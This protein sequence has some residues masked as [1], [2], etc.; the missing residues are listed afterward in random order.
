MRKVLID[1]D[2]VIDFLKGEIYSKDLIFPLWK[3]STAYLSVLTI[4]ELYAGIREKERDKTKDF[5]DACIIE[6]TTPE[7]AVK[8]GDLRR[9]YK[10]KGITLNVV[11]CL[12]AATAITRGYKIA[13]RNIK[14]Y[15]E[16]DIIIKMPQK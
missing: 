15:P 7:I 11:D 2:V 4:Y 12:I 16:K 8:G 6:D 10:E 5:I 13:T 9:F 1:T 3:T 14:H